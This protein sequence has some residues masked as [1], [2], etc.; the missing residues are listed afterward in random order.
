LESACNIYT[1]QNW[2]KN[3]GTAGEKKPCCS[4]APYWRMKA[5]DDVQLGCGEINHLITKYHNTKQ[6]GNN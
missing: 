5:K 3:H 4:F 1:K 6:E 2:Q